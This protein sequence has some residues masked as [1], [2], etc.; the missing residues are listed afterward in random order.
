MA[1]PLHKCRVR[2]Y[3]QLCLFALMVSAELLCLITCLHTQKLQ[4]PL[5]FFWVILWSLWCLYNVLCAQWLQYWRTKIIITVLSQTGELCH[6]TQTWGFLLLIPYQCFSFYLVSS[7][8]FLIWNVFPL[9]KNFI[10]G[11]C[12]H[13]HK[14][15]PD[16]SKAHSA[17]IMVSRKANMYSLVHNLHIIEFH[18]KLI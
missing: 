6:L 14:Q 18:L 3:I 12:H 17:G 9:F 7:K 13:M 1:H 5:I 16:V 10:F 11:C 2:G 8:M 15:F 4:P